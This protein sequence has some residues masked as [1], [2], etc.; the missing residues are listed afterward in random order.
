MCQLNVDSKDQIHLQ[1]ENI[2]TLL[3][4]L[5]QILILVSRQQQ[6]L[7]P[8]H[9]RKSDT[10]GK[11]GA[12]LPKIIQTIINNIQN[13]KKKHLSIVTKKELKVFWQ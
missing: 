11:K 1:H 3:L 8:W 2:E 7:R 10:I 4:P 6:N 9:R 12:L 13:Q 5:D